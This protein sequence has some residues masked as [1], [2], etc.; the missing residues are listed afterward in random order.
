MIKRSPQILR[1]TFAFGALLGMVGVVEGALF[2]G[3]TTSGSP[4]LAMLLVLALGG[5]A[6]CAFTYGAYR[7]LSSSRAT[8]AT[9]FWLY[10]AFNTFVFPFGTAMAAVLVWLW[11]GR[12]PA[13]DEG[14]VAQG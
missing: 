14:D 4:A 11:R 8:S 6:W 13:G 12:E 1:L 3:A 10:V 5:G 9:V 7:G 2:A